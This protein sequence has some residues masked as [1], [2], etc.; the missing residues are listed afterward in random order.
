LATIA[1]TSARAGELPF[2]EQLALSSNREEVLKQLIPGTED[3]YY[4][5]CLHY[6]NIEQ[7]DKVDELIKPWVKQYNY[8]NR[9]REI[10]NRQA[11]L[12][13]DQNPA[14][15]LAY[16][17][18]VLNLRF[19]HRRP[20][21][22]TD[23]SL[24]SEL[25]EESISR[26]ALA[27]R[28]FSQHENLN[29]FND[30]ALYWL[31]E[32]DLNPLQRR[33]LLSRLSR[34]DIAKLVPLVAA[35]LAYKDSQGFGSLPIHRQ[36]L[37]SQLDE[38]LR[39][40]PDLRNQTQFVQIYL[41]KLAP[42]DD[43]DRIHDK[44]VA[45]AYLDRVWQFVKPLEPVHNSLKVHVLYHLLVLDESDGVHDEAKFLEYVSLPR[46]TGYMNTE[47]MQEPDS[48]RF[49][50]ELNQDFSSLTRLPAVA[51]DEP[52]VR[53][54]LSHF[55]V[56]ATNYRQYA[57]Y[58]DNTYLKHLFAETKIVHGLG[59]QERWY[60][61]LPPEQYRQ[62]K[63][64]VDVE[65]LPTNKKIFAADQ[66]VAIDLA[67]KNVRTLIVKIYEINTRN[68]YRQQLREINTD[69]NLDGLV[70]NYETTHEYEEPPL[71]RVVRHFEFP[72]LAK[73]G[74][75]VVDFIGNGKSSRVVVRKGALR[76]L[77]QVTSA[78][79]L[80]T[81]LDE[82]NQQV[83]DATLWMHGREF[84]ADKDGLILVPFSTDPGRVP[85]VVTH[86]ELSALHQ[87]D[88]QSENYSLVAGIHVDRE[89]LV[90]QRLAN[91]IVRPSLLVNGVPVSP[92]SLTQT[93]LT[94]ETV[95]L[96]G[97]ES[98]QQVAGFSLH[99]DR[100]ST[101]AFRVPARLERV[102]FTLTGTIKRLSTQEDVVLTATQ[103][104]TVNGVDKTDK[105]ETPHLARVGHE[106]YLEVFGRNGETRANHPVQVSLSHR[107]FKEPVVV[108]LQTDKYGRIKLGALNEITSV[109]ASLGKDS[110]R[111]W[112]IEGDSHSYPAV[113][114]AAVGDTIRVPYLGHASKPMKNEVSLLELRGN[115]YVAD[116]FSQLAL[117]GG[118]LEISGLPA[119]DYDLLLRHEDHNCRIRVTEGN[120]RDQHVFGKSRTLETRDEIPLQITNIDVN[121]ETISIRLAGTGESS[122][123]HVIATR[124]MPIFSP[125]GDLG[126]VRNIPPSWIY[127]PPRTSLYM[128]GRDIGDEYR[129]ILDR[130]YA[131]Q[132]PGNMMPRPGL[133]LNPWDVRDTQTSR[134]QVEAGTDF[135]P[136]MEPA[137]AA[138]P[139]EQALEREAE[140]G[141][142]DFA[143]LDFLA[144][145]SV[146][147]F[148]LEP[149]EG[150][151]T[152]K[153]SELAGHQHL[154]VVAVDRLSTTYRT[155]ALPAADVPF[156]DLRLATAIDP[157]KHVIQ[158]Q[159]ITTLLAGQKFEVPDVTSTEFQRFET[160]G[161]VFDL[162][163]TMTGDPTLEK[164]R[165]VLNWPALTDDERRK[166]YSE[167]ACH[168]LNFFLY[169]KDPA[170]FRE[171]IQPYLANKHHKTFLDHWL[172]N[173]DLAEDLSPWQF[174]Q[175]NTFE[176]I[177]LARRVRDAE[178]I[179]RYIREQFELLPIDRARQDLVFRTALRGKATDAED[180]LGDVL[181]RKLAE[182]EKIHAQ[183]DRMELQMETPHEALGAAAGE[184]RFEA[185]NGVAR[186]YDRARAGRPEL[187]KDAFFAGLQMRG[188]A[189]SLYRKLDKTKEWA[190]N[191][192]YRL[193]IGQQNEQLIVTS[194]FWN[195]Y[196]QHPVD[197][198]F[199]SQHW[200][201]ATRNFSEMMMALAVLD[202]PF[203]AKEPK[204][205]TTDSGISVTVEG[206]TMFFHQQ[207][208]ET[209]NI[210]QNSPVLVSQNIFR[211]DDRHEVKNGRQVDKFISG[212]LVVNT[213]YGCQVVVTNPS[214]SEQ[215]VD[216]LMQIPAGAISVSGVK[217][218]NTVRMTLQ[219]FSTQRFEYL[220][221]FPQPGKFSHYPV[222]VSSD[223][224]VLAYGQPAEFNVVVEATNVDK[225]S[226]N[227]VAQF[228]TDQDVLD[229]LNKH[230]ILR[231]DLQLIAYRMQDK[232]DF[233]ATVNLLRNR[234]IYNHT[235]WS[236]AVKHN[237]RDALREFLSNSTDFIRQCGPY[238]E[239]SLLT[240]NPVS[241]RYYEHLEYR[242]LVNARAHQLGK[243]REILNDR[244][245]QQYVSFMNILACQQSISDADLLAVTYYLL[246]QDRV[247]EAR[248]FF[249]QIR[250]DQLATRL[251]YD[252]FQ[253]YL[254]CFDPDP[255]LARSIVQQYANHPVPRW[256]ENFASIQGLL[257]EI[258][259]LPSRLA[260]PEDRDK[261]QTQLAS[262]EPAFEFE[263]RDRRVVVKHQNLKTAHVNFYLMDLELLFSRN[264]FVQTHAEQ[265]ASIRPNASQ[266]IALNEATGETEF[267]LP[268]DLLNRNVLVEITAAGSTKA[269]PYY[270]NS[271][272]V[273]LMENYGQLKVVDTNSDRPATASYVKVYARLKDG[274][275]QFYKDGYTDLRG[276]FDY[277][278]LSTND[279]DNVDRFALLIMTEEHGATVRE[280]MPPKR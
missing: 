261:A 118:F 195:D 122:R 93:S 41:T 183:T 10:L 206:P 89:S 141:N 150:V 102:R 140:I 46:N 264:P 204:I 39:L 43:A 92:A 1:A 71:R 8:T 121:D 2:V 149:Q 85:I 164:F 222:H 21:L 173:D 202:L 42:S 127:N 67:I 19:D 106:Y 24:P 139:S 163:V 98:S 17:Q 109:T 217:P 260:N 213:V 96:D 155:L 147:M 129:Y 12:T 74:V 7:F 235:L 263:V 240:I 138:A 65:F 266:V 75:Y 34:P 201:R 194:A 257:D 244:F 33:D 11:I 73:N 51:N 56:K 279:L 219:P 27:E 87:F 36:M 174:Q 54:Y 134:Q 196:V 236:Y 66:T 81:I 153:R 14:K 232:A 214:S 131:T 107:D 110:S 29:G 254:N 227:Y 68:Y 187:G 142:V 91:V 230:N 70:A 94:I 241:R 221:Y 9:V 88:H 62:L 246:L 247:G 170:F 231:L 211:H 57:A 224:Q 238:L 143:N 83:M 253:A 226:W 207:L 239:S 268:A 115:A 111:T 5:H 179:Q 167:F 108:S 130:Q 6:Q 175:L 99:S 137:A 169:K 212:E 84:T 128:E 198:E 228:G 210:T 72:Q 26:Q 274:S 55:F 49:L 275:V 278:S 251:Q 119:G 76:F 124:F 209:N 125:Y 95:D 145:G 4:Y 50:A 28:A 160:L 200:P 116:R 262:A 269:Q 69:I 203:Q 199:F 229:Y 161:D 3:Y 77:Q 192:Y 193:P 144:T 13:Y 136:A 97:I 22:P 188:A 120:K 80:F 158:Q 16:L 189:V 178:S 215:D 258:D 208:Q 126:V 162:F 113:I 82:N 182:E 52:L 64:R 30:S 165:F 152:V 197:R 32:Q 114:H 35:D 181:G 148:N 184:A 234:R 48:R 223:D 117:G 100:E 249:G 191:N 177:L 47:F 112:P 220:F 280:A 270:S 237:D 154:Q 185:A 79:H 78:G 103:V 259:G 242:P 18:Q 256:R 31:A 250:A 245:F 243:N 101:Y 186:S 63:D 255:Q 205:E 271:L 252:Y 225:S 176:R 60:A 123:V 233:E 168:E 157:S 61:M 20:R 216:I 172:L 25:S 104:Y 159:K 59:D 23:P 53:R 15:S 37:L 38:L 132:R 265:F 180:K 105:L 58:I 273:Q 151:V 146:V 133:L 190:E 90:R 267:E 218:T 135:A 248:H 86:G 156:R 45:R 40:V 44:Q 166:Q 272:A 276:R 171:V 277:T